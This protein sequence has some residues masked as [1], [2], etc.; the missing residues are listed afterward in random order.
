MQEG[1]MSDQKVTL[2]KEFL[3]QQQSRL[4]ALRTTLLGGEERTIASERSDQEE[5]GNEAEEFEDAAQAMAQKE[6]NQGLRNAN[7]QRISDIE[8]AL[9][10]IGEGTYGISDQSGEPIPLAR[11]EAVPEAVLTVEEQ[12]SRDTGK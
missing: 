10:K 7:D 12:Q 6:I 2:G 5:H 8:R 9:Q 4:V 3:A 11:L 1:V